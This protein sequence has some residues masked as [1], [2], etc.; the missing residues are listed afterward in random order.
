MR[1]GVFGRKLNRDVK[2][3]K[4]LFRNLVCELALHGK[5][6]TTV[7][8]AK[9]VRGLVEKTVTLAKSSTR[10]SRDR[11]MSIVA[12]K[13]I[14]DLMINDIAPRFEGVNG[15]YTRMV[16]LDIRRGDASEMVRM[17]WTKEGKKVVKEIKKKAVE[18]KKEVKKEVKAEKKKAKK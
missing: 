13:D 17:E 2:E 1:H 11:L 15:G 14:F 4:A 5:I 18:K 6:S 10:P 12:R 9:A 3:R 16:K 8:K 7:S